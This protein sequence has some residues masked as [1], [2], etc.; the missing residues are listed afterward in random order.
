MVKNEE[1]RLELSSR[2]T[3]A[4]IAVALFALGLIAVFLASEQ[5]GV[6]GSLVS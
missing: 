6:F 4:V 1:R 5:A 2:I 3:I